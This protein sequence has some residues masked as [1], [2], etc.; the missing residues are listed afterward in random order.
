MGKIT[1]KIDSQILEP[2]LNIAGILG[3]TLSEY[4]NGYLR[5]LGDTMREDGL[6][7]IGEEISD[8]PYETRERAQ[9]VADR[10]E[11]F[12]IDAKLAGESDVGT[13]AAEVVPT[14]DGSWTV[15]AHYLSPAGKRWNSVS[16]FDDW[17]SQNDS[18]G[19]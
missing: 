2:W 3:M 5:Q 9:A 7:C 16:V 17:N 15:K 6:G 13:V 11:E 1:I 14:D 4:L 12:A 18:D 8:W 19:E 10:F